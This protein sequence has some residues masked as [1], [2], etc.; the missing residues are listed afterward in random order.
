LKQMAEHAWFRKAGVRHHLA[1]THCFKPT[2]R[3]PSQPD[4]RW[5]G[6]HLTLTHIVTAPIFAVAV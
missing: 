3:R 2:Q 1:V 5:R 4:T 6:D